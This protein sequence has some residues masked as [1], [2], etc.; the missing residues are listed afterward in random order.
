M[1]VTARL[2]KLFYDRLG[3]AVT[4]ELVDWFNQ[5]DAAYKF[6]LKEMNELNFARFDAKLD[7]RMAELRADIAKLD[8]KLGTDIAKLDAKLGADIAKLDA[9]LGA[10]ITKLDAKVDAKFDITAAQLREALEKA[11]HWQNRFF[12]LA[13]ATQL[14]AIIALW[15]R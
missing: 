5:V 15:F 9:K 13:W 7:Q 8:A 3:E 1:P 10:D 4:N 12:F 6:D 11:L 14:A 2:S